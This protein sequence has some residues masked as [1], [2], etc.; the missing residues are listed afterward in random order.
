MEVWKGAYFNISSNTLVETKATFWEI[1]RI[2]NVKC[3]EKIHFLQNIIIFFLF[4]FR[5][6]LYV[7]EINSKFKPFR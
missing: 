4:G 6:V 2:S 3:A 7:A 1:L 5:L